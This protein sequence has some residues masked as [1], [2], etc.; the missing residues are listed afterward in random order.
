MDG[1]DSVFPDSSAVIEVRG[2]Y[3]KSDLFD[4]EKYV[5]KELTIQI[6]DDCDIR[7]VIRK[8]VLNITHA[9]EYTT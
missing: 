6:D 4:Y 2:E 1:F 7:N 8:G 5:G 9:D 3:L